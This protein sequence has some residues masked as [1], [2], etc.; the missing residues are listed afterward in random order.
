MLSDYLLL[1]LLHLHSRDPL[2]PSNDFQDFQESP[3]LVV[4][5]A[6]S[7]RCLFRSFD[8]LVF[9]WYPCRQSLIVSFSVMILPLFNLVHLRYI[10]RYKQGTLRTVLERYKVH[11][12]I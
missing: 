4:V 2:S 9:R 7:Y 11:P 10:F 8:S 12:Y 1:D 5:I 3:P 6:P